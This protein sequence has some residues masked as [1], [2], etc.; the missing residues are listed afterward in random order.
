M[1]RWQLQEAKARLSE[2]VKSTEKDG[3]QE[4]TVRGRTAAVMV[5][6]PEYRRLRGK[7]PSF[8]AFIGNSPLRGVDLELRREPSAARDVNL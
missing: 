1:R 6:A 3:P 2:V 8:R 4:I 5:S 7:K